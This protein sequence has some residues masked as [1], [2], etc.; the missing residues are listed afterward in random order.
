[1]KGILLRIV[2]GALV[3]ADDLSLQTIR[4]R[5]YHVGDVLLANLH[6][7]RNPQFNRLVHAFGKIVADNIEDFSGLDAHS[8][9]KRLQ[10]EAGIACDELILRADSGISFVQRIPQSLSFTDMDDGEFRQVYRQMAEH[11]SSKYWP[12][13]SAEQIEQMAEVMPDAG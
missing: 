6:K 9:L 3:P 1:V 7:P 11:V 13:V 2:K 12:G 10:L 4:N 5:G 8:V